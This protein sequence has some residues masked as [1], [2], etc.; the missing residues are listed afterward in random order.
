[1]LLA[2][3]IIL[4]EDTAQGASGKEDGA[5]A[6][7]TADAGFLPV[8]ERS[9]GTEDSSRG[10]AVARAGAPVDFALARTELAG[11]NLVFKVRSG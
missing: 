3:L 6:R 4:A 1:M 5:T 2:D 11:G 7:K 10:R 9:A 8:V